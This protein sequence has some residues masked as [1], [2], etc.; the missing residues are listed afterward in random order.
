MCITILTPIEMYENV[1]KTTKRRQ[2]N[3][4]S[5]CDV[6]KDRHTDTSRVSNLNFFAIQHA[7]KYFAHNEC[8]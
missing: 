7:D 3:R 8:I 5:D 2:K 6:W 1:I 4:F